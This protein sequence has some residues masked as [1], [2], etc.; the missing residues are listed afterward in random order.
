MKDESMQTVLRITK[1][2]SDPS[3]LRALAALRHGELCVCQLIALLH[4]APST[5]SRHLL[6]LH[7]ADLV[8]SRK[9][10]RWVYY[11]L[12]REPSSAFA[13]QI[14]RHTLEALLESPIIIKDTR[15]LKTIVNIGLK[16]LCR[17]TIP[18]QD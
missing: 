10:G 13:K 17:T 2:L 15:C 3:R 4:L 11:R 9:K 18:N 1:A 16:E 5:V 14:T 7:Q 12:T 6:I 8:E